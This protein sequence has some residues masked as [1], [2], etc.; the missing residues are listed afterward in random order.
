MTSGTV[1]LPETLTP[2]VISVVGASDSGKT[3]VAERLIRDLTA[4]ELRIASVKHCP[5]G[6]SINSD[7]TDS[8]RLF[9]AGAVVSIAASP[10]QMTAV[11][12]T[13]PDISLAAIVESL[14]RNIDL[15][16]AEG[17][18]TSNASKIMVLGGDNPIDR[19]ENIVAVVGDSAADTDVPWFHSDDSIGLTEYVLQQCGPITPGDRRV[20]LTVD[21]RKVS[22]NRFSS[23]AFSGTIEGFIRSLNGIPADARNVE[24]TLRF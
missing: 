15:V 1:V 18:K 4:R 9:A 16:I 7:G 10:D 6:H 5:H 12:R 21:G 8:A 11:A 20:T 24:I 3:R 19:P 17:F 13:G 2:P 22:L 23:S 14:P